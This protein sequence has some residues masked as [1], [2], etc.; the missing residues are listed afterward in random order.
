MQKLS[1][2]LLSLLVFSGCQAKEEQNT[3][4][5]MQDNTSLEE[6]KITVFSEAK[7]QESQQNVMTSQFGVNMQNG[8]ITI[9]TEKT[10]AFLNDL[11][12]H[13]ENEVERMRQEM[14]KGIEVNK[15]TINIDLN[16]TQ[17]LLST[18]SAKI[19]TFVKEFDT[20]L[21]PIENNSTKE[22]H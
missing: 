16:R 4:Q 17:N 7:T 19:D 2:M 15:D 6:K 9:N 8:T 12:S 5:S 13:M 3:S 20:L 14:Q 1:F 10:K 21:A 11:G 18:W 22:K